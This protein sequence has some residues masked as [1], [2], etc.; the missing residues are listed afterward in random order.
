MKTLNKFKSFSL[1]LLSLAVMTACEKDG[2]KIYLSELEANELTATT[3][4]VVLT[5]DNT[6]EQ[7]LS[8]TWTTQ[9]FTVSNPDMS[10]PDLLSTTMQTSTQED[11][12]SNVTETVA[13]GLSRSYTGSELNTIAKNLGL[14]AGVATTLYFRLKSSVGNNMDPVYSNVLAIDV[15]PYKIDMS[16][17]FVLDSKQADTGVTLYSPA[18]DGVYTGF[19]GATA[20]YNFFLKEGDGTIWG[21]DAA[22]GTPFMLSSASDCWNFWFPGQGG[23]YY[24][25]VDTP[26]KQWSSLFLPT[27]TVSGDV[28]GDMTFDRPNV[29]WTYVFNAASTNPVKIKLNTSGSLYNLATGTEDAAAITTPVA[30]VQQPDGTIGLAQ[31]AGELTVSVPATGECTLTL[32]LSNPKEWTCSIVSGS[33]EPVAIPQYLYLPG[34][35]DGISGN[36]TF[37]NFLTLYDEDNLNYAGVVN[38]NSLWGYTFGIEKDNW[39]D[40]YMFADGDAYS[41]TLV[42]KGSDNIPAPDPGLYLI[43]VSEKA[44]TYNLTSVGDQIYIVGLNKGA[45]DSW[46]FDTVLPA[47]STPGVYSGT[48]TI[49]FASAWGFQ[50]HLDDTWAHYF[51]GSSGTLYYKGSNITDDASLSTGTHQMTV[52]LIHGTYSIE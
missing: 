9:A 50:I 47:T 52:D 30:F 10:A 21:N 27:L 46:D 38:V 19:M 40:N 1:L 32:D 26:N 34:I 2:T 25:T 11:F 7:V 8:F 22:T 42:F 6:N 31:Q 36:W 23:C 17:G 29:K 4:T 18:S 41:G 12:T 15:T 33:T 43:D 49:D 14:D 3:N 16:V 20:W 51:G 37:D 35:D 39:T 48:I 44:L 45:N 24:V 28:N 5:Q 13:T